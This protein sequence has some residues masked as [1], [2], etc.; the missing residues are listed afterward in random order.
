M[1]A[2]IE[3]VIDGGNTTDIRDH[4]D[5]CNIEPADYP[6]GWVARA[7]VY[8]GIMVV[9]FFFQ[10]EGGIRDYKVTGVQACALPIFRTS[11]GFQSVLGFASEVL[12]INKANLE[13]ASS[14]ITDVDVAMESTQLARWNVLVQAGTA[15]LDRKSVV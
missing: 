2:A 1:A 6:I 7:D 12:T 3:D 5:L 13:A 9:Q 8:V 10:A 14:R 15:M 11:L 4:L